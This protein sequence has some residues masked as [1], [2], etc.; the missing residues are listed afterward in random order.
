MFIGEYTHSIDAKKRLALPSKVRSELG[1]RVV[2]TRGLDRCLFVYPIKT[3]ETLAE[4]LGSMPIGEGGTRSF[5]RLL[6]AGAFDTEVDSQGRILIPESLKSYAGLSKDVIVVGL[7][8]RLEV[9][10]EQ[11]WKG[12]QKAAEE[13][14]ERIAE[15]L[16]KIGAY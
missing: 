5:V 1:E 4:K 2:V 12:Y 3:W 9:W 6:L 11:S 8:N 15:E 16:G 7:W 14:S 10:D 13:N